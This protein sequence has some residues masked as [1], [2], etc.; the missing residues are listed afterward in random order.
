MATLFG[1]NK[2]NTNL[3]KN[4]FDLSE[5]TLFTM[6]AGQLVPV[7]CRELNP[8]EKVQ[9]SMSSFT[10]T[11][12][13]NTAAFVRTRQYF[14]Y[15]FVPYKQLWAGWDN[16]INGVDYRTSSA[17]DRAVGNT[18]PML[19]L[20]EV[21]GTLLEQ[22]YFVPNV[23]SGHANKKH[24][25]D[26]HGFPYYYG[27][28]RLLDML[29]YG[30]N[31]VH[32][33]D[34][35]KVRFST[36]AEI[37]DALI[38]EY[39]KLNTPST[40]EG[41]AP[42]ASGTYRHGSLSA[43]NPARDHI[44][45]RTIYTDDSVRSYS[46]EKIRVLMTKLKGLNI[47]VNPF[48]LLAYQKI[49]SDFYKRDDYEMTRP[50]DFN[51]DDFG[52]G[53]KDTINSQ[54]AGDIKRLLGMLRLRYRWLPKDYFT[55]VVPSELFNVGSVLEQFSDDNSPINHDFA[56]LSIQDGFGNKHHFSSLFGR[57]VGLGSEGVTTSSIRAAFA[58]EKLLR[59]TRRAGGHDYI[60]QISAHYGFEPP[61][62]RG[63][64]VEF[65][66]GVTGNVDITE[67]ITSANGTAES[68]DGK[69]KEA[70]F[71]GQ[72]YGKGVGSSRSNDD[73]EFTAKEHG[74]LMCI[75]SIVPE[76]DYSAEG[77]NVFNTKFKRGD[78]FHPELQDLGLQP[79]FAFELNHQVGDMDGYSNSD[80]LGF[81]PR[82][83]EYKTAYDTLHGE[84]RNGRF[85]STWS[86]SQLVAIA[87]D[88]GDNIEAKQA[89]SGISRNT[90]LINPKSLDRIFTIAFNGSEV[91][92]QF[93]TQAQFVV[94]VIRPMSIT[95]QN[96]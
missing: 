18:V 33:V 77:L 85:F 23:G 35:K 75:A 82:Y 12:P 25:K 92:D 1:L 46:Q 86:A 13:L 41:T 24:D 22:G 31:F 21:I 62:G 55:G 94:K 45:H 74:I 37:I 68:K 58:I 87:D 36:L 67:I 90:L 72:V 71:V 9:L 42:G 5:K 81:V 73:I 88:G 59:L 52:F 80:L 2:P 38:V 34:G 19:D 70:A 39:Q 47:K 40:S 20:Y 66:G 27:I 83:A 29:G 50:G 7:L 64:K 8:S 61:K 15:F 84:F 63:D 4:V 69:V 60:S 16:F 91:T 65:L 48:R 3:R 30:M 14:H 96:L 28:S 17:F 53:S 10:R 89:G 6:S 51:I 32:E 49:Y 11:Q 56:N 95:G 78:Y 43:R 76:L 44:R 79:V 93:M 26:E 57:N 54:T